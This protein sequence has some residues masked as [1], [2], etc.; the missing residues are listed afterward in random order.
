MPYK[1]FLQ[2]LG[3]EWHGADI[4]P[5]N[6][7]TEAQYRQVENNRLAWPDCTFDFVATYHVVEH[8]THP[9][10]MFSEIGRVIKDNGVFF[11]VC[12]FWEKEHQSYFHMTHRGLRELLTRHGFQVLDIRPSRFSGAVLSSQRF[13][14]GDGLFRTYP[15]SALAKSMVLCNLNWIPF[16][17]VNAFEGIRKTVFRRWTN[18]FED[19]A[20]LYFYARKQLPQDGMSHS[21]E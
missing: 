19:C 17:V 9:E 15:R 7:T 4:F 21:A 5:R 11:G 8:F 10:A 20:S 1:A 14:G 6:R 2:A 13:F 3:L 16:L 12:A 18:P